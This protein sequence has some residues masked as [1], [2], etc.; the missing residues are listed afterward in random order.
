MPVEHLWQWLREDVT[1]HI[2]YQSTTELVERVRVFEQHITSNSF[3]ISD[4]L[5]VKNHLEPDEEK[6]R[7]SR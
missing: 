5:W 1:Y 4:R 6:L 7:V 2:Y 3:E